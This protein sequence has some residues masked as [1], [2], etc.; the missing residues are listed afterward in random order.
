[1]RHEFHRVIVTATGNATLS[2]LIENL[3]G[4]TIRARVWRSIVDE[5]A[6]ERTIGWHRMMVERDRRRDPEAARAAD[7]LHL[8]ESEHWLKHVLAQDARAGVSDGNATQQLVDSGAP[9]TAGPSSRAPRS[10]PVARKAPAIAPRQPDGARPRFRS[11][12]GRRRPAARARS[13]PRRRSVCRRRGRAGRA[14]TA[15]AAPARSSPPSARS[16]PRAR[17]APT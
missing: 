17:A 15:R 5:G 3:W 1:M 16:D 10:R 13:R 9:E 12:T 7:L 11:P 2:S 8:T 14:G 4:R 6:V